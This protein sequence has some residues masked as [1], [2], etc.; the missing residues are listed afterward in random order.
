MDPLAEL[1]QTFFQECEELLGALEQ[2][3]QALDEGSTDSEDVNAAFRAIHSIKG[4]AGAFG[5][6][7]LVGFA[8]VF[9]AALDHLRSGRV[10]LA[11]A[12][13]TLFLRCSD[14]VADLV[15]AARNDEVAPVRPDLLAAL[16]Q[17]GQAK[18]AAPAAPAAPVA[19]PAA[20]AADAPVGIAAL[21]N[22]LAMVDAKMGAPAAPAAANDGWDD[23]EPVAAQPVR[24]PGHDVRIKITPE[25]DLFRRVIEPRVAI[26]I[27]PAEE[28]VSVSCDLSHVPPLETLDV[29]DCHMR[30]TVMMRTE[31]SADEIVA[32][33]DFTL[34]NEEFEVEVLAEA[35]AAAEPVAAPAPIA[36]PEVPQNVAADLS[37]I[38]ARLGPAA[39]AAPQPDIQ[40]AAAPAVAPVAA[41][42]ATATAP[43]AARAAARPVSN[44]AAARQRQAVSV[45]V[46][47]DRIDR[48]MNLVGEIVI[49][50][51]MLVECVR[52]LPYDVY[53]KTAEGILTLS[54]QTRELQD[55]VMAV[56]AQ[57]VKA[58]FQ[59]MPRLV[60]ELA[61]TLGK[62]VKLVLEGE[63]TEVDKTI[64]EEL[65][66]PLTHMIRNSMDHGVETPE[67]RI[68]AGK[69]PEGTIR[70]IAEHRA[71][72]IVIS[73][74]DDG[75]GIGRDR[76]LAKA[77]S[78]GLVGADEKLAPE[79]IDQLIFAAG[80]S[81]ADAVSDISGRGVGMD[82]V[83]RN[84]ESLGGRISVD[85]EPGR[86]CKF[87]LALP[88]TLAVLEGMVIRCGDDRYVIPIASVIE[89]QHLAN[90]PIE[91]LTFGQEVLRWRGEITPL[92]RLGAVMGSAGTRD[93]NI[94]IIAETERGGNVGIAVD[95]IVGQQQVVV[96]SLES[97]YGTVN[98]ASAATI[99][100]DGLVALILDVDS[101]L[102]L[103]ASGVRQPVPELKLAG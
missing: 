37:A 24:K 103:A 27:L 90:T 56:R 52:S 78:R 101:M 49:T 30:F 39:D 83:R 97:N 16:E 28:I 62:E 6:T 60:R 38:L 48:L 93:E 34:A 79:E 3:L 99:L 7:E 74:T 47:L 51:S 15:A 23:D 81:T 63:N 70:L 32:K 8:H 94:I 67:E 92:H 36:A 35:E 53:A 91:H 40:P 75:R 87:T 73:V 25:A 31:L 57:P 14:A 66:D 42:P 55:H 11:D 59:R 50:Q 95:E 4:G 22:L 88:L 9:E 13:F 29:T 26:G 86:G 96:K 5:C 77:K 17:V 41:A 44:E 54:R 65:A 68:A 76:L 33:F 1:K 100:G 12:P 82:V 2:K 84:V 80:L 72:R 46:D 45:R 85:S 20:P 89:T 21:G 19:P 58:V 18:A 43:A 10:A 61:Q 64:I 98:G 71:G 69:N 102:R